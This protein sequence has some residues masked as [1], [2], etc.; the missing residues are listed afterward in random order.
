MEPTNTPCA[1]FA[2]NVWRQEKIIFSCW[3]VFLI[4]PWRTTVP[5]AAQGGLQGNKT[6]RQNIFERCFSSG[7]AL[8]PRETQLGASLKRGAGQTAQKKRGKGLT[9]FLEILDPV[10]D[11]SRKYA[12]EAK[13]G[14]HTMLALKLWQYLDLK[15][16]GKSYILV[17]EYIAEK[18]LPLSAGTEIP[19]KNV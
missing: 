14:K 5:V 6:A 18:L 13:I 16:H 11:N 1:T 15:R 8:N 19:Y 10:C 4:Y 2:P 17:S 7:C 3:R 12:Q 9:F